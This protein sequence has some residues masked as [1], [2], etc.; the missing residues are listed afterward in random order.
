MAAT[1]SVGDPVA[2]HLPRPF[3]GFAA[4]FSARLGERNSAESSAA[5][6]VVGPRG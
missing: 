5:S 1:G 2:A 3:S 4:A 6:S